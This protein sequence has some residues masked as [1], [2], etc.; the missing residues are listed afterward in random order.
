MVKL[1]CCHIFCYGQLRQLVDDKSV[2]SCQQICSRLIVKTC[3]PDAC[4]KLFQQ[5]V[6]SLQMTS[7][8][9]PGFKGIV[10]LPERCDLVGVK[11]EKVHE[12]FQVC[13]ICWKGVVFHNMAQYGLLYHKSHGN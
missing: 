3:Y 9:K 7:W 10:S 11:L 5:V 8:N 4:C 13:C 2:A 12:F 6:T 1:T